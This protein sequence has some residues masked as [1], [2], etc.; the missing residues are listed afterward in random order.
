[1]D[2]LKHQLNVSRYLAARVRDQKGILAIH[3]LGS[4]KTKTGI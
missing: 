1:M 2:L 3:G 4:G